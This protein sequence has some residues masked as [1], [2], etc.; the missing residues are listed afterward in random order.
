MVLLVQ[1]KK[2]IAK[3]NDHK[4]RGKKYSFTKTIHRVTKLYEWHF[5]LLP[6]RPYSP[7]MAPSDYYL[8]ANLKRMLQVKR[9]DSS[10][11]VIA[12]TEAYFEAKDKSFYKKS[13][14]MLESVGMNVSPL[15]EIML[16]NEWSQIFLKS[17][18]FISRPS[19]RFIEWCV[20]WLYEANYIY[21]IQTIML[22][23]LITFITLY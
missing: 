13:I 1:L 5:E 12:E 14:T 11:E 8:S 18:C 23:Y 17:C 22:F 7:D 9:F 20:I 10:E 21:N 19:Y 3:K 6:N 4:W 16:M 15:K 2:E